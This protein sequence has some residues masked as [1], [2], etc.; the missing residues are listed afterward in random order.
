MV[1]TVD[2]VFNRFLSLSLSQNSVIVGDVF[3]KHIN[4]HKAVGKKVSYKELYHDS[5]QGAKEVGM[6]NVLRGSKNFHD[7]QWQG[8]L[9]NDLELII[10]LESATEISKVAVGTLENQGSGIYFP[11]AVEVFV[12][13]DSKNY[14]SV[15]KLKRDFKVNG[16]SELK[17]FEI[18]FEKQSV[19]YVK[20][21]VK[22]L[23]TPP[24]GG[25]SWMFV[26]EIIV[27]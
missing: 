4:Y 14:S 21:K 26:D 5:Y 13:S 24:T 8:W 19:Q 10:N 15:G 12:S 1:N 17:N 16:I 11:I 22:N 6:V 27:E 18:S 20:V 2:R 25:G 3:E 7:G 23:G 9:G